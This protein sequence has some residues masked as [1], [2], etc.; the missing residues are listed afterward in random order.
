MTIQQKILFFEDSKGERREIGCPMTEG[1]ALGMINDF[2]KERNFTICYT[3]SWVTPNGEKWYDVGSHTE[4][5]VLAGY[6][7]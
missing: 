3:R 5:F 2:C 4:F 7:S 6:A 1:E